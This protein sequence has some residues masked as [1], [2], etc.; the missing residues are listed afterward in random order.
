MTPLKYAS[1]F[2]TDGKRSNR[3]EH[4]MDEKRRAGEAPG[5]PGGPEGAPERAPGAHPKGT[6]RRGAALI[7]AIHAA[8]CEE[9]AERGLEGATMEGIARRAGTAKTSLYRRWDSPEDIV[10]EALH[11]AY[12]MEEPAPEADDLRGD[13]IRALRLM[14][15][16]FGSRPKYAQALMAVL[17]AS[18]ARPDL[19]ERLYREVFDQRGERFTKRALLHY[20]DKGVLD[21]ERVT[22][23]VA[24]IGE[25]MVFKH[26]LDTMEPP[27]DAYLGLIVDQ[28]I[29]PAVGIDP[30]TLAAADGADGD[31]G[32][33][34]SS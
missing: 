31:P 16:S 8:A 21:R 20:A 28:A 22:H 3:V 4:G 24:D 23:V 34:R 2:Y 32:G 5:A 7:R 11:A 29:L 6:R 30:R 10:L 15:D 19:H 18:W 26:M 27:D 33:T 25:A 13:L 1:V 14:R 17:V 9:A 12:P